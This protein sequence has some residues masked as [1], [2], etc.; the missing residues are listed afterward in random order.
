MPYLLLNI[1]VKY[2]Y[3]KYNYI[4]TDQIFSGVILSRYKFQ[5]KFLQ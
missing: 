4:N 3:D 5:Y 1:L 2:N